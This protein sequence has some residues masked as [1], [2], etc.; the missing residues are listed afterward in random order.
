MTGPFWSGITLAFANRT[1]NPELPGVSMLRLVLLV[2]VEVAAEVRRDETV[3]RQTAYSLAC[4]NKTDRT[5]LC[6]AD[7]LLTMTWMAPD[8][9]ER[10]SSRRRAKTIKFDAHE[11]SKKNRKQWP[12]A[13][14]A[15]YGDE[16][17][18]TPEM[19]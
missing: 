11:W 9:G 2:R 8:E 1:L 12:K 10:S 14:D 13:M 6:D 19:R 4:T 18:R 7:S 16:G 15:N 3:F 5:Q 17:R